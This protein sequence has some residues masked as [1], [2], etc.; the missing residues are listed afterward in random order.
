VRGH[1]SGQPANLGYGCSS[2][3]EFARL[4]PTGKVSGLSLVIENMNSQA[5]QSVL[6]LVSGLAPG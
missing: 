4:K 5:M 6:E 2:L 3:T 1:K